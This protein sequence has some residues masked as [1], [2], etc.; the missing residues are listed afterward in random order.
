MSGALFRRVRI[1]GGERM[2]TERVGGDDQTRAPQSMCE[3]ITR[4][5]TEFCDFRRMEVSKRKDHKILNFSPGDFM[6]TSRHRLVR[7]GPELH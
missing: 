5:G 4:D 2:V 6:T 3:N 1:S 7:T